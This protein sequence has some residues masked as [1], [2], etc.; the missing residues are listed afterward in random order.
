MATSSFNYIQGRFDFEYMMK[1]LL[2]GICRKFQIIAQSAPALLSDQATCVSKICV[3]VTPTPLEP[4]QPGSVQISLGIFTPPL[5]EKPLLPRSSSSTSTSTS[6]SSQSRSLTQPQ[7]QG[8]LEDQTSLS[9]SQVPLDETITST[10]NLQYTS[11]AYW[12]ETA[13]ATLG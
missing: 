9:D 12:R 11:G 6:T 3:D 8:T 1:I 2:G 5:S 13:V 4:A 7:Q 10:L